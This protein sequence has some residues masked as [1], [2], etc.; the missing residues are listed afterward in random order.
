MTITGKRKAVNW[1]FIK[2]AA[3]WPP[4][5]LIYEQRSVVGKSGLPDVQRPA[6]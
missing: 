5:R 4:R 1:T 6:Q 3:L 2:E